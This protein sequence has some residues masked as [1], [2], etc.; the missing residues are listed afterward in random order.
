LHDTWIYVTGRSS[1]DP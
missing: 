1:H